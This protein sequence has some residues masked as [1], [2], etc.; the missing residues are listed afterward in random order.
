LPPSGSHGVAYVCSGTNGIATIQTAGA[1]CKHRGAYV[2]LPRTDHAHDAS[3]TNRAPQPRTATSVWT[4][5]TSRGTPRDATGDG[6][7]AHTRK[8]V[9][10]L[11]LEEQLREPRPNRLY[12]LLVRC[13]H[14]SAHGRESS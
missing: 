10:L 1:Q 14:L 7:H 9:R 5:T 3:S 12:K 8:N 6:R 11:G 2:S 13:V 4:W